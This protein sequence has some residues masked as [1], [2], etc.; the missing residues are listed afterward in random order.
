YHYGFSIAAFGMFLGLVVFL[1]TRRKYLGLAG[2]Y[3]ANP[4]KDDEKKVVFTRFGIGAVILAIVLAI[5]I[6][7][8][9]LNITTF[10]NTISVL[11]VIIPTAYFVVMYKSPKTN[12][13]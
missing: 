3:V 11:G 10:T 13:V 9:I 4:L 7:T 6:P 1:I 2:T 5:T 8:N 12:D